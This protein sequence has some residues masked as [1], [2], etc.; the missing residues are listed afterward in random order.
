MT[1][2]KI[3]RVRAAAAELEAAIND[4]CEA[5][6]PVRVAVDLDRHDVTR[7]EDVKRRWLYEVRVS[8]GGEM[9]TVYL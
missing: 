8:I 9:V 7:I 5:N 2:E 6:D 4:A 3:G 1:D